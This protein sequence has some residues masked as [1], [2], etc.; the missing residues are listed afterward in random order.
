MQLNR[1]GAKGRKWEKKRLYTR[2]KVTALTPDQAEEEVMAKAA[3]GNGELQ[4]CFALIAR[5]RKFHR[6]G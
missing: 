3:L 1:D 4:N 5:F 6:H 2:P